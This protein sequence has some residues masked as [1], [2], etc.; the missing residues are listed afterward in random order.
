MK[1]GPDIAM[2]ASL[3]GDPARSNMLTAL[4]TCRALRSHAR[5]HRTK[6]SGA[7][8]GAGVLRSSCRR[9][10][11]ADARQHET[12]EIGPSAQARDQA[13]RGGRALHG[14]RPADR[15]G[16]TRSSAPA[17]VQG[18]PRLERAAPPSRRHAR[19]RRHEQAH[20]TEMGRA[21]SSAPQPRRQFQPHRRKA[22][23][24]AVREWRR[25]A[26]PLF[27][28]VMAG[29][30]PAIPAFD[31]LPKRAGFGHREKVTQVARGILL[32]PGMTEKSVRSY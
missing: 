11:R 15:R 20:R 12:T 7:A 18:L 6:G 24:R 13:D 26:F 23:C 5:A 25:L 31:L 16:K 3:V 27:T 4:M 21:R 19:C 28:V 29:L 10:R 1:A 8:P 30:D 14:E 9:S 22:F 2:V 32:W 17:A